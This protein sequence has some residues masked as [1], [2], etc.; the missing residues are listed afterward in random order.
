MNY[1]VDLLWEKGA[2]NM[3]IDVPPYVYMLMHLQQKASRFLFAIASQHGGN[4]VCVG[5]SRGDRE[6]Q[7]SHAV[8]D[9]YV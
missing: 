7:A 9:D 5:L 2:I 8:V 3:E 1:H 6:L 4:S